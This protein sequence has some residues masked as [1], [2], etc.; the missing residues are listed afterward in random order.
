MKIKAKNQVVFFDFDNTITMH[1]V[2]DDMLLRFSKDDKWIA[3]EKRWKEGKIGSKKCLDGQMRGI[4]I[5]KRG[6]DNYLLKVK[7]DPYF[8]RLLKYLGSKKIKTVILSDNFDYILKRILKNNGISNLNIYSNK[9]AIHKDRLIPTFHFTNRNCAKCAHCK[10]KNMPANVD[11]GKSVICYVG[12]GRSDICPSQYADVIF[13]K[14][15]LH[16]YLKVEKM[17]HIPFR[18]LKSVYGYFQRLFSG[19]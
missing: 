17:P 7:I 4:R 1:D 5:T 2:L 3:L 16:S 13:A 14:A 10:K 19:R 11:K 18:N 12:D 9:L 15:Y 6:L 8:K